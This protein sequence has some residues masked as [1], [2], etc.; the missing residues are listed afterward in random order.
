ME[1][2]IENTQPWADGGRE[3]GGGGRHQIFYAGKILW[4]SWHPIMI[5]WDGDGFNSGNTKL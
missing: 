4:T 1:L 5:V 2:S 3:F